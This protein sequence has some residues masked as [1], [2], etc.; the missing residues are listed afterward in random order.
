MWL[1][2]LPLVVMGT[3]VVGLCIAL[4]WTAV[5]VMRRHGW[6]LSDFEHGHAAVLH[7]VIGVL[8]AVTLGL[9]VVSVQGDYSDVEHAATAEASAVS[10]LYRHAD[11]L[12]EPDRTRIKTLISQYITAVID[13]EWPALERGGASDDTWVLADGLAREVSTFTPANHHDELILPTLLQDTQT[14]LD[15]RRE[16]IFRGQQGLSRAIWAVICLGG[17][18]T[19]LFAC[20]FRLD[21]LMK[22]FLVTGALATIFGLMIFLILAL[23][24]PL[25]GSLSV[26]PDA[27]EAIR[28]NIARLQLGQ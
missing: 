25:W 26:R 23:D 19:V 13:V 21:G 16:R 22:H 3:G 8:Y 9:I 17:A 10:D 6:V 12:Q 15:R 2:D 28:T 24:H 27:F 1:Y 20:A 5:F 14:L 4:T 18:V 7:Q 11:G